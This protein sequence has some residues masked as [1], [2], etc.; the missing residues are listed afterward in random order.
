[1]LQRTIGNQRLGQLL[2]QRADRTRRA[3]V[4]RYT[5]EDIRTRAY[6]IYKR[7]TGGTTPAGHTAE[8]AQAGASADWTQARRELDWIEQ[9]AH[10]I[11]EERRKQPDRFRDATG[12]MSDWVAAEREFESQTRQKVESPPDPVLVGAANQLAS[13]LGT[14][15]IAGLLAPYLDNPVGLAN[16]RDEYQRHHEHK[17]DLVSDVIGKHRLT[18]RVQAVKAALDASNGPRTCDAL[19][20]L[21]NDPDFVREAVEEA[22]ALWRLLYGGGLER[23]VLGNL[24]A[25]P[26]YLSRVKYYLIAPATELKGSDLAINARANSGA[27]GVDGGTVTA[28][29]GVRITKGGRATNM[30]AAFGFEY[31]GQ[32]ASVTRW[33]Q[34]VWREVQITKPGK[35]MKRDKEVMQT[36][37]G[38]YRLTTDAEFAAGQCVFNVDVTP[39]TKTPYYEDAGAVI[40]TPTST[41]IY[42]QPSAGHDDQSASRRLRGKPNGITLKQI[43]HFDSFLTREE[44]T[45]FRFGLT[46]TDAWRRNGDGRYATTDRVIDKAHALVTN[47]AATAIPPEFHVALRARYPTFDFLIS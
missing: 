15:P 24:G 30:N 46:V 14:K 18:R 39:P 29:A 4:Q 40:R 31:T 5:D 45:L 33:I 37:G 17:V 43:A 44:K 1:M 22:D 47:Q 8:H 41:A 16:L 10:A 23:D 21:R 38:E 12:P 26:E 9:R 20:E 27:I 13:A 32:Q 25:Q 36:T 19:A 3:V 28:R 11:Y 42:D 6:Y 35:P 34:F 7:R 2:A